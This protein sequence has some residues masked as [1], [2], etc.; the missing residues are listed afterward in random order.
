MVAVPG[1]TFHLAEPAGP[2]KATAPD[3]RRGHPV[4]GGQGA[5]DGRLAQE[6]ITRRSNAAPYGLRMETCPIACDWSP[7]RSARAWMRGDTLDLAVGRLDPAPEFA[8]EQEIGELVLVIGALG[9]IVVGHLQVIEV[10]L[11]MTGT[12]A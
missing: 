3:L 11:A 1:G 9:S 7:W 6:G 8:R 4:K 5:G 12:E 10:E 2:V